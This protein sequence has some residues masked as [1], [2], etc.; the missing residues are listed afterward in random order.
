MEA[1]Q[2]DHEIER[3]VTGFFEKSKLLV[4]WDDMPKKLEDC[5]SG[6]G[7]IRFIRSSAPNISSNADFILIEKMYFD[8]DAAFVNAHLYPSG[9]NIDAFLR[10]RDGPWQV[11]QRSLWEN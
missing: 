6:R 4:L 7:H 1:I 3:Y 8:A 5:S 11:T 9:K 10:K 2:K